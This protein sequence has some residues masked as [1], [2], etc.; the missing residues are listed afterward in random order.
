MVAPVAIAAAQEGKKAVNRDS[1]VHMVATLLNEQDDEWQVADRR[2]FSVDSVGE[3]V[4]GCD[5]SD[6]S[7]EFIEGLDRSVVAVGFG[8]SGKA[9]QIDERD[10][11]QA[12]GS[13]PS[14]ACGSCAKARRTPRINNSRM[15]TAIP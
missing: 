5:R 7:L 11:R 14:S 4:L 9:R 6:A 13:R 3:P 15:A 8:Q 10:G 12:T 1:L 2:Y